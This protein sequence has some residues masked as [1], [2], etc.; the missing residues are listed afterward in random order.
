MRC[1]YV[2]VNR[3]LNSTRTLQYSVIERVHIFIGCAL[4]WVNHYWAFTHDMFYVH[5]FISNHSE[6]EDNYYCCLVVVSLDCKALKVHMYDT[7]WQSLQMLDV[8]NYG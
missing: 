5:D 7:I 4:F 1:Q 6:S 3:I 8:T 2:H